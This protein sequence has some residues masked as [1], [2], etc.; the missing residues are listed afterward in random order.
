VALAALVVVAIA[1]SGT[2]RLDG[3]AKRHGI[4]TSAEQ[5]KALCKVPE[6]ENAYPLYLRY[7]DADKTESAAAPKGLDFPSFG[8]TMRG[9][10]SSVS[11]SKFL[12]D[13]AATA[14]YLGRFPL[15]LHTAEAMA[16]R[17]E[18]FVDRDM[19]DPIMTQ[20]PE[21]ADLKR[22]TKLLVLEAEL[23][24]ARGDHQGA[25]EEYR[26]ASQV[27]DFANSEP[28]LIGTLVYIACR[29]VVLT[30]IAHEAPV[31]AADRVAEQKAMK[32]LDGIKQPNLGLA[33]KGEGF[34]VY[35]EAK[36]G[37]PPAVMQD[38]DPGLSTRS[39]SDSDPV[40]ERPD[41]MAINAT[42]GLWG[43]EVLE[44]TGRSVDSAQGNDYRRFV[45]EQGNLDKWL[46]GTG[47]A[48]TVAGFLVPVFS[49]AGLACE[50][51]LASRD[52]VRI[53]LTALASRRPPSVVGAVD[54]FSLRPYKVVPLAHGW[55]V[56]SFGT[57]GVDGGGVIDRS[58]PGQ[59]K[60]L[61]FSYDGKAFLVGR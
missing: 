34:L 59:T 24:L 61:I 33:M 55:E 28:T 26:K 36:H 40:E 3:I 7:R 54:P 10:A 1:N 31:I 52:L 60:D 43:P 46:G 38:G 12:F 48:Q 58:S 25:M 8:M 35:F 45:D 22:A 42:R 53:G 44:Q 50:K 6:A 19:S 5:L 18:W 17:S 37:V 41:V 11:A 56:Y 20:Y 23:K 32:L 9:T 2:G 39:N 30:S 27:A 15:S 13:P 21:L 14:G 47:I 4:P 49:Q 57:D 51:L 16:N 29:S